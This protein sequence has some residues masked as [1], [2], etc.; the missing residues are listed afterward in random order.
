MMYYELVKITI[1]APGLVEV[2]LDM[3]I[4]HYGLSDTI[5]TDRGSLFNLKFWSLLCYFFGIKWRLLTAFHPQTDGQ[6]KWQNSA[7]EA[8]LCAFINFEQNDWAKLILMAEFAYNN[9]K[10]A[11]TSHILFE[12]NYSYHPQMLY[13]EE[14][15]LY[16]KSKLA[17]ELSVKLRELMII[18]WE[19]LY[20][21][22]KL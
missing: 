2:I 9:A 18:C 7:M 21:A 14:V 3:V 15:D 5:I 19:N 10:N 8:Y 6:T 22:Q 17:D 1:D 4:R 13:K 11:S 16:S 20:Y 12:L